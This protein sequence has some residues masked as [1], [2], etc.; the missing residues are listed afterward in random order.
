MAVL[1]A[2]RALPRSLDAP[3]AEVAQQLAQ[4]PAGLGQQALDHAAVSL[5]LKKLEKPAGAWRLRVGDWRAVFFPTGE[6]FLV[7]AI[8][9]RKDIYQ[10]LDRMRLPPQ[11]E[12]GSR[13]AARSP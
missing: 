5:N 7:A 4:L 9:L 2:K 3:P 10:R 8:G 6:D 12:G 1:L 13:H 11:G